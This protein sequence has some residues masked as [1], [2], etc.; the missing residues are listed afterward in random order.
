ASL[1]DS[2][3]LTAPLAVFSCPTRRDPAVIVISSTNQFFPFD[4]A[5]NAGLLNP[6]TTPA[7]TP[8]PNGAIVPNSSPPVRV[9]TMPRGQSNTLIVGEKYV[10]LG[11]SGTAVGDDVSG[12]YVFSTGTAS[13]PDFSNVRFGDV[14]PFQDS[15]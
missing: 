15:L 5:G 1:T 14:G 10:Q 12:Y 3:I 13:N 9:S 4:Y 11:T 6:T 7:T 2:T 8:A